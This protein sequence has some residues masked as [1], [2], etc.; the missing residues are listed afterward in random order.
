MKTKKQVEMEIDRLYN[1]I[2]VILKQGNPVPSEKEARVAVMVFFKS[3]YKDNDYIKHSDMNEAYEL[4]G[5][6]FYKKHTAKS[7]SEDWKDY[8]AKLWAM[9]WVME[10]KG[11]DD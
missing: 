3:M 9:L 11:G 2:E 6:Y 4:L 5:R 10:A 8:N 7:M 1:E